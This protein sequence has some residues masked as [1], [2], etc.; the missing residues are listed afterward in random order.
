MKNARQRTYVV[1]GI[2][3]DNQRLRETVR[4]IEKAYSGLGVLNSS[5]PAIRGLLTVRVSSGYYIPKHRRSK[6]DF[7]GDRGPPSVALLNP[8]LLRRPLLQPLLL[9]PRH[10][11]LGLLASER[12][13][14]L[15]LTP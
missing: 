15:L 2:I 5:Q 4:L 6:F 12:T 8:S 1:G 3:E 13:P 14:L 11:V 7:T 10:S 9:Q